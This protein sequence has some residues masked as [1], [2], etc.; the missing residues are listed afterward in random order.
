MVSTKDEHVHK[1]EDGNSTPRYVH[2]KVYIIYNRKLKNQNGQM[3]DSCNGIL[4]SN[5]NGQVATTHND[6]EESHK[7]RR[8]CIISF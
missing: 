5:G 6:T 8:V 7:Y 2:Q 1:L 4:Y 3:T